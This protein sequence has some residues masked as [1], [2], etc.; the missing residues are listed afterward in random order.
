VLALSV[1]P[2]AHRAV[3]SPFAGAVQRYIITA[4]MP[5]S[6]VYFR[7]VLRAP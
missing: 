3:A 7:F 5:L 4:V 2:L 6:A 1:T